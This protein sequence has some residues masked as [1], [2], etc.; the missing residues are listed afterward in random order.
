MVIETLYRL[1][2][3]TGLGV[4]DKSVL[5]G[6]VRDALSEQEELEQDERGELEGLTCMA[7]VKAGP[8]GEPLLQEVSVSTAP[9][10]LGR[11][12]AEG[13]AGLKFDV[14]EDSIEALKLDLLHFRTARTM[15]AGAQLAG[16]GNE[17]GGI[18]WRDIAGVAVG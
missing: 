3:G 4:F 13:L 7:R 1:R 6:V 9:W 8:L 18:G 12:Q 2:F 15:E 14:F 5:A 16:G 10:A 11:V 17:A